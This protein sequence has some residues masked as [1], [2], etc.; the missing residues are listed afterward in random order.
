MNIIC[1]GRNQRILNMLNL[2]NVHAE[3]SIFIRYKT[4]GVVRSAKEEII[5]N[6]STEQSPC[7]LEPDPRRAGKRG[8]GED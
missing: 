3:A 2:L 4:W 8:Q 7:A 5:E 1:R 6:T